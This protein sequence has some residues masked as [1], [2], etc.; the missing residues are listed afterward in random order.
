M[1]KGTERGIK[2]ERKEPKSQEG[3]GKIGRSG[4]EGN[5]TESEL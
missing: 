1:R 5:F 3:G 4:Q 2:S